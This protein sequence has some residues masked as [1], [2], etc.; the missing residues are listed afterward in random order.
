MNTTKLFFA[1]LRSV[2]S[3]KEGAEELPPSLDEETLA[4]LYALTRSHDMVHLAAYALDKRGF[5]SNNEPSGK[6][7]KSLM[8][9]M[10]RYEKMNYEYE[11][12]CAALSEDG[13]A[14]IPLKG[15]VVRQYYPEPWMRTSCDIDI[16]VHEEELDSAVCSIAEK[17][18]Y[19][20]EEKRSFHDILLISQSGIVLELHFNLHEQMDRTDS[21]L[22]R[23]WEH[24]SPEGGGRS[25][26]MQSP[27][28]MKLHLLGHM[29]Y[30]FQEG[31][32]GIRPFL[33]LY[34][35]RKSL[36]C[37]EE[38]LNALC[39]EA[40]LLK[41]REC[42]ERMVDV[43][44]L[45]KEHTEL[46]RRI[47]EYVITGR[48]FGTKSNQVAVAQE[49]AG[50]KVKHTLTRVFMPYRRLCY[51][52]PVLRKYPILTPFYQVKRWC[53]IL[54]TRGWESSAREFELIREMDEERLSDVG[55]MLRDMG[56]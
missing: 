10:W 31:G 22:D 42:A 49:R 20:A 14:Y 52:Y 4:S 50:N 40:G 34:F 5:L 41:F 54:R 56:L 46:T 3:E 38:K 55:L 8:T 36:P 26:V 2:F 13:I 43:W 1:L 53:H 48:L 6:F 17:L 30:H 9:A 33:D 18:G 27:E 11:R 7:Q 25:S 16:L 19:T 15:S 32:C 39:A 47:E 23:V 35:L 44:F 29:A 21:V 24:S 51:K 28:F 45:G 12:I 37:D